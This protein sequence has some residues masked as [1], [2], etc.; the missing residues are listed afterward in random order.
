MPLMMKGEEKKNHSMTRG[1]LPSVC[2]CQYVKLLKVNRVHSYRR[3]RT[4]EK[5]KECCFRSGTQTPK[6]REWG[7]IKSIIRSISVFSV[8]MM[9]MGRWNSKG[10][11]AR[12]KWFKV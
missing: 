8:V 3:E 10:C 4:R 1:H 11:Q 5:K 12:V 7:A 9:G 6:R 2:Y